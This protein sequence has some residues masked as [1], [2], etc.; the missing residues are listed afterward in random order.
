MTTDYLRALG[1][2]KSKGRAKGMPS[3]CTANPLVIEACLEY[4]KDFSNIVIIEATANQVNPCAIPLV[5]F[6]RLKVTMK[7]GRPIL[8]IARPF[9][10]PTSTPVSRPRRILIARDTF[11]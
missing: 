7:G 9:K 2:S 11:D 4:F 6:M 1:K 3:F 8:V 10:A 5:I